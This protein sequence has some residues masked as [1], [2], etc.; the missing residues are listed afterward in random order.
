MAEL[1]Q[2]IQ[3]ITI[4]E[5]GT[6]SKASEILHI[7]Q[8]ALTRSMQKLE[9]EWNAALFDRKKNKVTLNKTGE[10][11]VQYAKRVIEA[12]DTMTREVQA[13]ERSLH[14]ISIGSCAPAPILELMAY[15]GERFPDMATSSETV[16][17]EELLPGLRSRRYQIIVTH[18]PIE[19]EDI[20]C[21]E[22]CTEQ[23]FLTV[24]PAH[25]LAGQTS[26]IHLED[27]ADET[28]LLIKFIGIWR[29]ITISKMPR[30]NFIL[31]D[32]DA[33]FNALVQ[34][35]ALPAFASNLTLKYRGGGD[36]RVILPILDPEAS[37][38][39]FCSVLKQN[40]QYLPPSSTLE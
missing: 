31:Q 21:R 4:A 19:A 26:G 12:A 27:L 36:N 37:I 14:T 11:A 7:S 8:P 13:Y 23:L 34:V 30:T 35:S 29:D 40:R 38:T 15:L 25:P 28:M 3:L 10:I 18:H 39:F 5:N 22:F 33:A 1:N 17:P 24:P 2:L 20:L 6:I 16:S 9:S 32:E